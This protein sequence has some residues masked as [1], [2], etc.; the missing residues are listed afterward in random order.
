MSNIDLDPT[1]SISQRCNSKKGRRDFHNM[2]SRKVTP[3][4][5]DDFVGY[6]GSRGLG[7]VEVVPE[8]EL[9]G[10]F[11]ASMVS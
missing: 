2:N 1:H 10:S 11:S 6:C 5:L 8:P 4:Y 3:A 9:I 7:A